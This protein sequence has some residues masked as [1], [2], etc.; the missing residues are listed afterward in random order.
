MESSIA[1]KYVIGQK[2]GSGAFGIVHKGV[3]KE[4]GQEIAI[5]LVIF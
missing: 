3:N 2:I 5:K 1:G 4:T